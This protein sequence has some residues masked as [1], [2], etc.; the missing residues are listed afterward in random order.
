M[1]S[2]HEKLGADGQPLICR[3]EKPVYGA[4]QSGRR[5]QRRLFPWVKAPRASGRRPKLRPVM[6]TGPPR[7]GTRVVAVILG[8]AQAAQTRTGSG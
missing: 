8:L 1:S 5:L 7:V 2:G 3:I 6:V 4:Q